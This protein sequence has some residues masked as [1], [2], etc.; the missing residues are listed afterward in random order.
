MQPHKKKVIFDQISD[1][2]LTADVPGLVDVDVPVVLPLPDHRGLGRP[3][4]GALQR[5]VATLR[6]HLVPAAQAV[7][8]LGGNCGQQGKRESME[9]KEWLRRRRHLVNLGKN[10]EK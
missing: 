4:G 3:P 6:L 5:H 7:L 2:C 10:C 9:V 1:D 8:D